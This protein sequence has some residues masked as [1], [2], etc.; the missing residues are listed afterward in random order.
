MED[1]ETKDLYDYKIHCFN[2]KVKLV[3]VCSNRFSETG[4]CITYFDT[5]WNL[6]PLTEGGH[7]IDA[8]IKRPSNYDE[9]IEI[10][11]KLSK[12]I[13]FVRID[14]YDINGKLYFGEFTFFTNAGY[15]L[16]DPEEWD[17]KLGD[18]IQLPNKKVDD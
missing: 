4:I 2:G 12:N 18:Y 10:S 13:P 14:W 1:K 8:T 9:M 11:E 6:L 7:P 15:E 5:N 3:L 17:E 16:F